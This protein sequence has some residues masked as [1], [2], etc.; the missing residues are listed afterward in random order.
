[1][2]LALS[3][4]AQMADKA[5]PGTEGSGTKWTWDEWDSSRRVDSTGL[6]GLPLLHC[7]GGPVGFAHHG[8][9]V[10]GGVP[11]GSIHCGVFPRVWVDGKRFQ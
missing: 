7:S 9:F 2:G 6:T 3:V 1:M 5:N 4:R 11:G 10:D 8:A